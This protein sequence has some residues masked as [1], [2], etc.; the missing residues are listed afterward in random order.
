MT[1]VDSIQAFR[2]RVLSDGAKWQC[3]CDLPPLRDFAHVVLSLA[4]ATRA[5]RPRWIDPQ[6]ARASSRATAAGECPGRATGD[7]DGVG[8]ADVRPAVRQ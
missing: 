7:R 8:V 3:E 4:A 5:V 2:L 6:T 1:L